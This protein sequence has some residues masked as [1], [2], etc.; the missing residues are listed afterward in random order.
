MKLS[1]ATMVAVAAANDKKV[2][3]R[4]PLNRLN[5]LKMFYE[6]F[7]DDV[8]KSRTSEGVAERF[9]ARFAE[10]MCGNFE[11]AFN[12]DNCGYY[13]SGSK[14]GG[15][16]PNPELRP[17][18]KPRNRRDDDEEPEVEADFEDLAAF[19]AENAGDFT[20]GEAV[21]C[22]NLSKDKPQYTNGADYCE[23]VNAAAMRSGKG[24]AYD[25]L[26]SE[27]SLRWRQIT[28]GTRKWVERYINNCG[29]QRKNNLGVKRVRKV[30]K[31]WNEKLNL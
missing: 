28:T 1:L 9:V 21:F 22:C 2:P 29:G 24:N 6:A 15:P 10:G 12:R 16:D 20:N 19:C 30:Y 17:N 7:G 25:R 5:K 13:D 26:A 31:K 3:P 8:V 11:N 23:G 27:P 18:G 14:H 4:H